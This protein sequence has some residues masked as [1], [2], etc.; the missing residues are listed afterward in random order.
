[1]NI[2]ISGLH[3]GVG[4]P[5]LSHAM[6]NLLGKPCV[7]HVMKY[8]IGWESDG[9]KVPIIRGKYGTNFQGSLN[10]ML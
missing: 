1:M 4:F 6:G 5:T 7:S 8:T 3:H 9:R 10:S 2:Y